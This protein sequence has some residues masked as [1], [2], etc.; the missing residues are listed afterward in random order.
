MTRRAGSASDSELLST[1]K[2]V[3]HHGRMLPIDR[4]VLRVR[5]MNGTGAPGR[6]RTALSRVSGVRQ[7]EIQGT[8]R[9]CVHYDRRRLQP[10]DL[11]RA[12][13]KAGFGADIER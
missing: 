4:T 9:A 1:L 11:V 5:N 2:K 10:A 8:E 6:V 3:G 7:V 13:R 12:V